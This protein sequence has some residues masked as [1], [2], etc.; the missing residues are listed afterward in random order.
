MFFLVWRD[1][2]FFFL[3]FGNFIDYLGLF[4]IEE[5][6]IFLLDFGNIIFFFGIFF[7]IIFD[8]S[9]LLNRGS[10]ILGILRSFISIVFML[11][12]VVVISVF[13]VFYVDFILLD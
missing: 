3:D 12:F 13:F 11:G 5:V 9:M 7:I 6:F 4:V 10:Y 2:Y 8:Y 1:I